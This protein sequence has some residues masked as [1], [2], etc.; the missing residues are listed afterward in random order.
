MAIKPGLP[1]AP[2]TPITPTITP[3]SENEPGKAKVGLDIHGQ[4]GG[5]ES[6]T[7]VSPAAPILSSPEEQ[8]EAAEQL[9]QSKQQA[10]V[11]IEEEPEDEEE[12]LANEQAYQSA[13]TAP[14]LRSSSQA[15]LARLKQQ[16]DEALKRA[17]QRFNDKFQFEKKKQE[18]I[19]KF[20]EKHLQK[21]EKYAE[22]A[23]EKLKQI[24]IDGFVT[25]V[26]E[27]GPLLME[28]ISWIC[29]VILDLCTLVDWI[30]DWIVSAFNLLLRGV[31]QYQR[32]KKVLGLAK[33]KLSD[34]GTD[35]VKEFGEQFLVKTVLPLVGGTIMETVPWVDL[36]PWSE[37]GV[38]TSGLLIIADLIRS[39]LHAKS[40]ENQMRQTAN[41]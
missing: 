18:I 29:L 33:T 31:S 8:A 26:Q 20:R 39:Y 27:V 38:A 23:K 6:A 13:L 17:Q 1:E 2:K 41:A 14:S 30:G 32:V 25:I 19:K 16:K 24:V 40:I 21:A 35:L 9:R 12:E 3:G 15:D 37:L 11:Q 4:L 10:R 7:S 5:P 34:E 28:A 22:I 36:L